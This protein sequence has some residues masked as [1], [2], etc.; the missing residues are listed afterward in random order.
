MSEQQTVLPKPQGRGRISLQI[1]VRPTGVARH[2][3]KHKDLRT[4]DRL[5]SGPLRRPFP[6]G[7]ERIQL[8]AV[9]SLRPSIDDGGPTLD[10]PGMFAAI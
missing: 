8:A 5:V 10:D 1:G 2:D 9:C 6:G 7:H 3:E 4:T